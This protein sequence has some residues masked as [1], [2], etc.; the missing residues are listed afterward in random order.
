MV[1]F[2]HDYMPVLLDQLAYV[3]LA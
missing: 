1:A 2:V 3:A